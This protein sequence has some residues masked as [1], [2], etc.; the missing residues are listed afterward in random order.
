MDTPYVYTVYTTIW[1]TDRAQAKKPMSLRGG[2][3]RFEE[4]RRPCEEGRRDFKKS[5]VIARRAKPD[6]ATPSR[7]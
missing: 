1:L 3:A 4:K 7:L 5:D 2:P 6:A